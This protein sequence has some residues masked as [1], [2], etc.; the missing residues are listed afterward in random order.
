VTDLDDAL[1][2]MEQAVWSAVQERVR[3]LEPEPVADP[4]PPAPPPVASRLAPE[5]TFRIPEIPDPPAPQSK[6]EPTTAE[7]SPSAE[8]AFQIPLVREQPG[9][10]A[11]APGAESETTSRVPLVRD[12]PE[13]PVTAPDWEPSATFQI[14]LHIAGPAGKRGAGASWLRRLSPRS[15]ALTVVGACLALAAAAGIVAALWD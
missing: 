6:P 1:R 10:A 8:S 11:E 14:P 13:P 2:E 3:G 15:M 12:A 5:T 9:P 7:P 4:E